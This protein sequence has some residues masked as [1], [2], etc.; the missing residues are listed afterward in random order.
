MRFFDIYGF[1]RAKLLTAV[2]ADT[3]F[4][5]SMCMLVFDGY[6][7]GRACLL[8]YSAANTSFV[9]YR[10]WVHVELYEVHQKLRRVSA[11]KM[12]TVVFRYFV[13]LDNIVVYI[14]SDEFDILRCFGA[15]PSSN[16][17][18]EQRYFFG[19]C[20]YYF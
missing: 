19:R 14:F 9:K 7:F 10:S 6:D 1:L 13:V 12:E 11:E 16:G 3:L 4:E 15:K 18:F 5:V 2:T 17:A 8:T 20:V